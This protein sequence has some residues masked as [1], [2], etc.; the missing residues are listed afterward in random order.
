MG[1]AVA[2]AALR[3][4]RRLRFFR[5]VQHSGLVQLYSGLA[6]PVCIVAKLE[7]GKRGMLL[8]LKCWDL[9]CLGG[10][11]GVINCERWLS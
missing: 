10:L 1:L 6:H 3:S 5:Y 11:L 9:G 4:K 7:N 2:R 8:R